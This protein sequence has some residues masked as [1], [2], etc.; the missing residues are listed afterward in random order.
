MIG[1]LR[2]EVAALDGNLALIDV[3]GVGYEVILPD[4]VAHQLPAVGESVMLLTRQIFRE[5][6]VTLYGFTEPFQRR[7]FD[8]LLGVTGCGPKVASGLIGQLGEDA[9]A[10]AILNQD[11]HTLRKA[12]GV[13]TKLAERLI[14]ELKDR[15]Q[16]ESLLQ[17]IEASTPKRKAVASDE[18]VEALLGLGYRRSEAESAAAEA[19]ENA[20]TVQD[21][22]RYALRLL[23]K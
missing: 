7:L 20:E 11:A 12:S 10:S 2:G 8:M 6:G 23:Q 14:L 3:S 15:M 5:D 1:R 9:V 19:R 18:L 17:K 21:Q 16:Q 22:I 13:G 4:L